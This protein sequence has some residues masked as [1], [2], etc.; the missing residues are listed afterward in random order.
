MSCKSG[1]MLCGVLSSPT[2]SKGCTPRTVVSVSVSGLV[3]V[4]ITPYG[5]LDDEKASRFIHF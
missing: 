2:S 4:Y 1:V 3:H 5:A